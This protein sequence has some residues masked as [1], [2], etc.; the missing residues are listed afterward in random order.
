M[1]K[2]ASKRKFISFGIVTLLAVTVITTLFFPPHV[3]AQVTFTDAFPGLT[4]NRPMWFGELPGKTKTYVV[5]EQ[6]LGEINLIVQKN[7]TW[8]KQNFL[9]LSV[10]QSNEMGLLGIAFHPDYVNNHKYYINYDPPGSLLANIIEERASDL[11]GLKDAGTGRKLINLS[12]KYENHNG[13]TMAFGKDGFLYA[14]MGDGGSGGDPDG[15]GQNKNVLLG[16]MLRIDVNTKTNG[17]EY[18]IP[19][20]NPF[21]KGGGA[22]E[23][24][25]YGLRN[26]WKWAFDPLTDTLWLA[27]VG[28]NN[29]EEVDIITNGGNYGWVAMEGPD[30]TNDGTMTLPIFSYTH[31]DGSCIIGG[32]VYRGN[33]AS[34]YYGTFFASDLSKHQL[35]SIKKNGSGLATVTTVGT[36]PGNPTTFGTD[37]EGKIYLGTDSQTSKIYQLTSADL[38]AAPVS[39]W[40]NRKSGNESI[41]YSV[42]RGGSLPAAL[43]NNVNTISVCSLTG[44]IKVALT[45]ENTN[46][47]KDIKS[48]LYVMKSTTAGF[49]SKLLLVE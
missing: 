41:N 11:T 37:S 42:N 19:P 45:V 7:G 46:L 4:F 16:K 21:A 33:P 6:H 14:G 2:L 18:G 31:S 30:G 49:Q 10:N 20:S 8:T 12:D 23:I 3:N 13:G 40:R 28:Q 35:Y 32:V 1:L 9:T 17:K 47:P 38:G 25:A 43:F 24:Y 27:D 22:P 44:E 26:P 29:V 15:N 34:K 5:L 36:V 39:F 48:G